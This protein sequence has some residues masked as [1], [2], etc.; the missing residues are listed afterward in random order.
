MGTP[1]I[2]L[3]ML[4]IKISAENLF[5]RNEGIRVKSLKIIVFQFEIEAITNEVVAAYL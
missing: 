4:Y 2:A 1:V 5:F 3:G